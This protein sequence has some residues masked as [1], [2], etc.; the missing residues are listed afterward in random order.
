[1]GQLDYSGAD[2]RTETYKLFG[3][4]VTQNRHQTRP[5]LVDYHHCFELVRTAA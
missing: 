3:V 2:L 4:D 5:R 1:L